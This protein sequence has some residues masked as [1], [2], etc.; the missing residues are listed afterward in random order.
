MA[1]IVRLTPCHQPPPPPQIH[2]HIIS[3]RTRNNKYPFETSYSAKTRAVQYKAQPNQTPKILLILCKSYD[4]PFVIISRIII[5]ASNAFNENGK[6]GI[7][8]VG[9]KLH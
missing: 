8:C 4:E 3:A 1:Q 5:C 6:C 2:F 7:E 9:L